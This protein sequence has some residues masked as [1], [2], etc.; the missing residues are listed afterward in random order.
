[1]SRTIG[2]VTVLAAL[3]LSFRYLPVELLDF[4]YPQTNRLGDRVSLAD[5]AR[6]TQRL[7]E[8]S[9]QVTERLA[10][11]E[12]LAD[13]LLTGELTL[14]ETAARFR[15]LHQRIGPLPDVRT[16]FG[17]ASEEEGWCR[18]VMIWMEAK[19][20]IEQSP[21]QAKTFVQRLE[22]ELRDHIQAHD[23]CVVLPE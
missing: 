22:G 16:F 6:K 19:V 14:V 3:L 5:E 10:L 17:V 13:Q 8:L 21:V 11:K 9:E 23:N 7:N 18:Q 20:R 4:V 15:A 1:M 2:S 12:E